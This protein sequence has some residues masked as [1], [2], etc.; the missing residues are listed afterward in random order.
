LV[1]KVETKF[2][3]RSNLNL[4]DE[5]VPDERI[6][7]KPLERKEENYFQPFMKLIWTTNDMFKF[8]TEI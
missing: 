5:I 6:F 4:N 8:A 1:I 7:F 2:F 3:Y